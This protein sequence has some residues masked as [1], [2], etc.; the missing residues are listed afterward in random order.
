V[1]EADVSSAAVGND[2]NDEEKE[3]DKA[4]V[5]L[6]QSQTKS[7]KNEKDDSFFHM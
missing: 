6:T 7:Q 5:S 2:Q 3:N 4:E 1:N